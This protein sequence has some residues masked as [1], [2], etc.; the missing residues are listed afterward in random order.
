MTANYGCDH[1]EQQSSKY[2]FSF[3]KNPIKMFNYAITGSRFVLLH[4]GASGPHD[5]EN[6]NRQTWAEHLSSDDETVTVLI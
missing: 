1:Y 5:G 4:C 2:E 3:N 6:G